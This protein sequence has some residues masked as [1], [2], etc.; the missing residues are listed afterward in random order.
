MNAQYTAIKTIN[1][2]IEIAASTGGEHQGEVKEIPTFSGY[3]FMRQPDDLRLLLL[4]PVLRS[5]ALDMVSDGKTFK[6][7]VPP[8]SRAIEGS[9]VV[10][11]VPDAEAIGAMKNRNAGLENLRPNIIRDA[12][13]IPPKAPLEYMTITESARSLP[14][15][16]GTKEPIEEPDYDITILREKQGQVLERVRVIHIGRVTLRPYRQDIYDHAGHIVTTVDY[17]K[18]QKFGD[19]DY[20]MSLLIT[21]PIDAYSLKIDITKLQFNSQLDDDQFVLKFP[22][23]LKVEKLP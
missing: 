13:V 10:M 14:P 2:S 6:L 16:K 20:P 3:M 17:D 5:R 7:L 22:E 21:R 1:A 4:I 19:I 23:N 15:A 11:D 12:L 9:D 18:Y 8:K